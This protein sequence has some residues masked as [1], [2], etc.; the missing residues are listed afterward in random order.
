MI[1]ATGLGSGLDI[2]G[3][4][5]QL[6]DAE[7]AGSDLQ[8][9]RKS[10]KLNAKLSAFGSIKSVVSGF[11]GSLSGLNNLSSYDKKSVTLSSSD[12][13]TA[14]ATSAA[15]PNSYN[16]EVQQLAASQALAST[17]FADSDNSAVGT[18][19]LTFR[20]GNVDYNTGTGNVDSFSL[21][22]DSKT[23][24]LT[25]DS[26]NNTLEGIM[27]AVNDANFGVKASVVNDG[28][29]YRILF[30]ATASGAENGVEIAV[31][32]T[33]TNNTDSSGLSRFAFNTSAAH[34]AQTKAAANAQ[35]TLNGLAVSAAS[36]SVT[37]AIPGV[38]LNLKN[39]S[40]S[41]IQMTV[42][43]DTTSVTAAVS[44]FINGYNNFIKTAKA[45]TRY[46]P[47]TNQAGMLI[48]DFTVRSMVGQVDNIMRNAVDGIT[49]EFGS[50]AEIGLS[51][52]L[53]GEYV[54]D[55][56]KFKA[57]LESSPQS[58]QALFTA[59]GIPSDTNVKYKS[60][61]ND[62]LT[63]EYGVN[64]TNLA[65]S[66]SY[67]AA[68]VLPA[69]FTATPLII[70]SDND[71]LSLKVDGL[72]VGEILL[73]QGSYSSGTDLA[74]E[75]QARINGAST[76]VGA[77]K[78]V[79]VSYDAG[80][81][82]F[83][84]TANSVGNSSSVNITAVD[85]SSAAQLGFTV[86]DGVD[87]IDVA[88]TIDGIA[89]SGAGT[90]LTA[91]E[92]SDAWGLQLEINGS[93]TG[94]RGSVNFS[95]GITNQLDMLL[96]KMLDEDSS[97]ANRIDNIETGI[98]SVEAKRAEMELR[99]VKIKDRYSRQFNAL[100]TMLSG[101]QSTSTFLEGQLKAL[102]GPRRLNG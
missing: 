41:A 70:D 2:S 84:I 26:S 51:T 45:L 40:T 33:D 27:K 4:V 62:T 12:A 72:D 91:G 25:I 59:L 88:G 60:S 3:L 68:G 80:S 52:N 53:A 24:T 47:A 56:T 22:P 38:T 39:V 75:I 87:G 8:L 34:V 74:N 100:D 93:T 44:S 1:T 48:G 95:R 28:T 96:T 42:S 6:V 21:K 16:V 7:R 64:V 58:M 101:L 90:L 99:W 46:D 10:T 11:K 31:S 85:T 18:G 54:L 49:G 69:D 66:G 29:G 82:A 13:F 19:T 92:G 98:K 67:S 94:A 15:V 35:F 50:L 86:V 102:P 36:N 32:D 37:S 83:V 65:T 78:T 30:T 71:A 55:T 73:T 5:K 97:L 76:M 77:N 57:K 89:A 43:K 14:I 81:N 63:G 61:T 23:T 20:F 79:A 9:N 17:T